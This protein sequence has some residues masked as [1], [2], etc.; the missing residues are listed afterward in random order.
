ME[1]FYNLMACFSSARTILLYLKNT[2]LIVLLF[3]FVFRVAFFP[4]HIGDHVIIE[5]D[6]VINAAQVGS[7]VHIGKNCVIV[8][9][10]IKV[11]L[12]NS[13]LLNYY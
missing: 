8:S 3:W 12:I 4:L 6:C 11:Y 13:R 7:Y 9:L 5:E 1:F 10:K 2:E